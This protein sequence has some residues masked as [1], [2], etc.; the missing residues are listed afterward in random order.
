[1][2]EL[3]YGANPHQKTKPITFASG[4]EPLRLLN[5]A[6]SY[7]NLLDALTAW[8]L[9]KELRKATGLPSAASYK[10][11]SPAGAAVAKEIDEAF[12]ES[13]F[14]KT[15]DFSPIASAYVR[16]RGGDRMCSFGDAAAV[17]D[18]VDVSLAN[19][20]KTEVCDLIIAPGYEPEALDI[21][22]QKKKGNFL[23][24]EIDADFDP[25]AF[26]TR[27]LFGIQLSQ[28]RNSKVITRADLTDIVSRNSD[29]PESIYQTLLVAAI[30]LK[31]TQ[32]NSIALA[33]EGQIVGLG[34]G[35]QSRI[36]CTRLACDKAEKW[37]LQRHPKVRELQFKD[38]LP[39]VAKTNLIDQYLLWDSLS[40]REETMML[41]GFTKRPEPISKEEKAQWINTF[42][43]IT[44]ASDAFIPFRDNI[45]RASRT[46]VQYIVETGGSLRADDVIQATDEYGMVHIHTGIRSFLH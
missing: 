45:D 32:S 29:M 15:T 6:P 39:K 16:A 26:E 11:V 12:K 17:S 24:F 23:I 19:F 14:L 40:S 37:F 46:N 10:H 13:Q 9:V 1:M 27:E 34:A 31:Y 18:I 38:K 30:T 2:I 20:L 43:G 36:H 33:Y 28:E 5:G 7:I 44:L 41:D 4:N 3:R 21:L 8:Q 35:Q 42:A 22:K 25:D